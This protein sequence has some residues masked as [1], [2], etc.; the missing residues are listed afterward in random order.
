M[1]IDRGTHHSLRIG[2]V[3][4]RPIGAMMIGQTRWSPKINGGHLTP[5]CPMTRWRSAAWRKKIIGV[6]KCESVSSPATSSCLRKALF[7]TGRFRKFDRFVS[8]RDVFGSSIGSYR[9][10]GRFRWSMERKVCV[11][12]ESVAISCQRFLMGTLLEIWF[13]LENYCDS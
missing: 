2:E 9:D 6:H 8:G 13:M 7:G 1:P 10:I 5:T 11:R 12:F 4:R 3:S